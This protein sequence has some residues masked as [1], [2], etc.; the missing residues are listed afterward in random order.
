VFITIEV[1]L[2]GTSMEAKVSIL[3]RIPHGGGYSLKT[4]EKKRGGFLKP[5][6]ALCYYIRYSDAASKKRVTQP[7]GEDFQSAV[8]LALNAET[9]QNAIR[10][11]REPV[12]VSPSERITVA[13]AVQDFIQE[14]K[15][16]D[17]APA[18]VYAYTRAV[19]QFRDCCQVAYL[20]EL[21]GN[22]KA[23][24]TFIQW[25]RD[26]TPTKT[27]GQ[28]NG[29]IRA[30]LQFLSVFFLRN[31]IPNPLPK[32]EWPK[33]DEKEIQAFTVEE[34]NKILSKATVDEYDLIQFL[35]FTGFR[36]DEAAHTFYS[37]VDFRN[38]TVNISN[39]PALG[40][41]VKNRKQRKSDITLPA[42]FIK[43]LKDRRKRQGVTDDA[44]LIFP[45][46]NGGP[47]TGLLIAIRKAAKRAGFE[48]AFPIGQGCH[49]LRKTFGT[50][51]GEKHGIV[52]AQNLLGHADIR[53][54]QKY[55]AKTKIAKK[56]VEELFA[57]VR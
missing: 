16:L 28:R 37:D 44:T 12:S 43:R 36:D 3:A 15:T 31:G 5:E 23:I 27:G 6:N 13:E 39:K 56:A 24:L 45:N 34:I 19:E 25:I 10:N 40:F 53:T 29:T 1:E 7:A 47:D 42:G 52:N 30:R 35:L 55:L 54:T 38:E 4:L 32:K 14:Q 8:V 20:D 21:K 46:R 2:E 50:W 41:T 57:G 11:D 17:K 18:T 26:N 51:Y 48:K 49:K 33:V 9:R 22:R